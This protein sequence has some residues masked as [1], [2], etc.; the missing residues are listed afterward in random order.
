MGGIQREA[1]GNN[2]QYPLCPLNATHSLL[3]AVL[4]YVFGDQVD[5]I[6][7]LHKA[8][9]IVRALA[10]TVDNIG[11]LKPEITRWIF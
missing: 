5:T 11:W 3:S 10:N 6:T 8:K 2:M 7:M 4:V 9:F 1:M